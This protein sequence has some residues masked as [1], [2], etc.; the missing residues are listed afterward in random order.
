MAVGTPYAQALLNRWPIVMQENLWAFG[1]VSFFDAKFAD[2]RT[3]YI[4]YERDD[5][6]RAI[7]EAIEAAAEFSRFFPMPVWISETVTF[8]PRH[9][10]N[11]QDV[12]LKYGYLQALGS[13]ATTLMSAGEAVTFSDSDSDS[14]DDLATLSPG[15][16]GFSADEIKV[17]FRVADGGYAAAEPNFEIDNLRVELSGGTATITGHMSLFVHPDNV[18]NI[19]YVD[20]IRNSVAHAT[21]SNFVTSADV[22]RIFTDGTTPV[23]LH[24]QAASGGV[25]NHNATGYIRDA[26]RGIIRVDL[27][28]GEP[29][30]T[31]NPVAATVSYYA[32]FPL[33]D[34]GR[35]NPSLELA[36]LRFANAR[37]PHRPAF[38][39]DIVATKWAGDN[40]PTPDGLLTVDGVANPFGLKIGEFE[41]WK[42][43]KRFRKTRDGLTE[44]GE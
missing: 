21:A 4:Q 38:V 10:Y 36:I 29:A 43:F 9:D 14:A 18:W 6:S 12:Q 25:D 41:A 15:D 5:I 26:E 13:R 39:Q 32:G 1:Q 23:I 3:A 35:V 20:G 30:L 40:E 22:Y 28:S 7:A 37:M 42:V 8:D 2:V 24:T 44:N 16:G 31:S 11:K 33:N 19:P 34:R 27:K 17:F